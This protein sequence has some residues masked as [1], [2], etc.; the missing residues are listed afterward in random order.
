MK[1]REMGKKNK[2]RKYLNSFILFFSFTKELFTIPGDIIKNLNLLNC[3]SIETL[4]EMEK[5]KQR[6][7]YLNSSIMSE[8]QSLHELR[9]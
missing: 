7:V 5:Q 6:G 4:S 8:S 2:R 1:L 3:I 9:G